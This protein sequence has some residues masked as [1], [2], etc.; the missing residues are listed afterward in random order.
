[1]KLKLIE[2]GGFAGLKKSAEMDVGELS[3]DLRD[4]LESLF[5]E[6]RKKRHAK[7]PDSRD[8]EQLYLQLDDRTMPVDELEDEELERLVNRMKKHLHY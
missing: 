1:M 3:A 5:D 2:A 7:N 4:K 6:K 8:R